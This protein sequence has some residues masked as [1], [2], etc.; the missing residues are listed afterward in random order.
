MK[1]AE[2]FNNILN[3]CL[4]RILKGETVEQCLLSYPEQAAELEPLLKTAKAARVISSV[5]PRPEFKAEARRQF[6]AALIEMKVN[7]NE[8]KARSVRGRQWRWQSG[9]AIALIAV[10]VLVV[11]GVVTVAAAGGSMPDSG[12]YAVKLATEKV[13]L[14]LAPGEIAKT[15]L[16]AKFADRRTDEIVYM[17]AQGN[18]QEVQVLAVR[19]N[20][21]LTNITRLA[22]G[23]TQPATESKGEAPPMMAPQF[24]ELSKNAAPPQINVLTDVSPMA[25]TEQPVAN[26][27]PDQNLQAGAASGT[28]VAATPEPNAGPGLV[29]PA[30]A[31]VLTPA[32][33]PAAAPVPVPAMAPAP[34]RAPAAAPQAAQAVESTPEVTVYSTDSALQNSRNVASHTTTKFEKL[35]KIIQENYDMRGQKLEEALKD[36]SPEVRPAIRQAIAQSDLEYERALKNLEENENAGNN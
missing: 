11:G 14:A 6:Q 23:N 36:A 12:L 18:A 32:P 19:L 15:E 20:T 33:V 26:V 31:P 34:A 35:R 27:S 2:K 4:D 7:Q 13:Q 9:W 28:G 29:P 25:T 3:E 17:A 24:G 16:N 5:Q 21:N 1:Q 30:A 22:A 8:S 10:V